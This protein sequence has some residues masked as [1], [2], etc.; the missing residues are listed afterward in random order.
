MDKTAINILLDKEDITWSSV[1]ESEGI[2]FS[3][4]TS[5]F[6]HSKN[7]SIYIVNQKKYNRDII[8]DGIIDKLTKGNVAIVN[9]SIFYNVMR[10]AESFLTQIT[11]DIP[12]S[13]TD[14]SYVLLP[15]KTKLVSLNMGKIGNGLLVGVDD[16]IDLY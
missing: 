3:T 15:E 10:V 13:L 5:I 16:N 6:S 8:T 14:F 4:F 7:G 12:F 9:N 11:K 1:L 2:P